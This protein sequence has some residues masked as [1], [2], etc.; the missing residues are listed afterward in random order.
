M[1]RQSALLHFYQIY[2]NSLEKIE[3][4]KQQCYTKSD[5]EFL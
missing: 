5:Y 1:L 2:Q 4:L 3:I